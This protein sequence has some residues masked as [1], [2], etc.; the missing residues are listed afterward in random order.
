M[1]SLDAD[2]IDHFTRALPSVGISCRRLFVGLSV[3]LS[4]T[5]RCSTETVKRRIAQHNATRYPG[6]SIVF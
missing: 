4:V 2:M 1:K 5:S 6:N 3:R